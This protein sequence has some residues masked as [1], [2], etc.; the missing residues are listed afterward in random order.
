[1]R[2]IAIIAAALACSGMAQGPLTLSLQQAMDLAAQQSYAVQASTLETEKARAKVNEVLAYGLPQVDATGNFSNYLEV[3]TMVIPNFTGEGPEQLELQFGVPWN[4]TGTV[5]LNQLIFDGS[6][7][8]GLN[9]SREFRTRTEEELQQA[10]ADARAQAAKSYLGVLAARE[11]VRL[12][13]ESVPVLEKSFNEATAMRD[14]GFM[15]ETDV[16]RLSIALAEARDRVRS[17]EQ[18]E[19]VAMAFL[20]LVLGV[21]ADTPITLT[22]ALDAIV[23]DPAETALSSMALDM[24]T[25]IEHQLANTL[26]RLQQLDLKNEKSAYL[27]KLYGFI[28]AQTQAYGFDRP[29]ETDWFPSSMWG[30]QLQVPIFSSG[31]RSNRVKQADLTLKQTEVNLAATEQRLIAEAEERAQ[32]ARTAEQ[33]YATNRQNLQLAQRI[34]DRT[35]IKFTNGLSTSFELNQDQGQYLQA[36]Q[37]YLGTLVDLLVARIEL[38]RA[39]DLY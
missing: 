27:P 39:L 33:S 2:P 34:F 25:H 7:I 1:M 29:F 3:P 28:N 35:S 8:V 12:A 22:D 24:N 14:Q 17:Y 19:R 6:Y 16:D 4:A 13:G 36:Q 5:Q 11:G 9:A 23:Q 26:V 37:V 30:L 18:Q 10:Q 15:E 31:M 32:K 21:P 20:R 38:R